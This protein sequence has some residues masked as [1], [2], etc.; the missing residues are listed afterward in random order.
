MRASGRA[1]VKDREQ[2]IEHIVGHT[3]QVQRFPVIQQLT[4]R[5]VHVE[6]LLHS[7]ERSLGTEIYERRGEFPQWL[8]VSL[9]FG[10]TRSNGWV[11]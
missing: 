5:Q 8:Y 10:A 1:F 9:T 6:H 3:I 4:F 2:C 7:R 11:S